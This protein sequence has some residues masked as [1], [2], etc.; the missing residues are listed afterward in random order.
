MSGRFLSRIFAPLALSALVLGASAAASSA[1]AQTS[2][3]VKLEVRI[4]GVEG[5][6]LANVEAV[7]G[8]V[9]AA[10]SG[11]VR[12]GHVYRLFEQ[13]PEEIERALEPFG[14]YRVRVESSLQSDTAPWSATFVIDRGPPILVDRLEVSIEGA[15]AQDSAFQ[16]AL[17]RIA[18]A[19]GDT[20]NHPAYERAKS[21]IELLAADRGYLDARW[22]S[23]FIRVDLDDYRSEIVLDM[24][25]GPRF[26][27]GPVTIDQDWV[28]LCTLTG[29]ERI[30]RNR[31]AAVVLDRIV[32]AIVAF[33]H[34]GLQPFLEDWR[35]HDLVRDRQV[36]LQLPNEV[37]RGRARGI[38][39]G[40]ALL[41]DTATGRRRFASGEVSLRI[42]P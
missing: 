7:T 24:T 23:A 13:A 4:T 38:D 33:E 28:D 34:S 40:G 16:A 3:G 18:L 11:V 2:E 15:A 5:A 30:S 17:G 32:E 12:P 1:F 8:I 20:L 14:Y 22:D 9:R 39:A 6:L 37:I 19:E 41:V 25:T 29:R 26:R 27:F 42:A 21:S 36:S 35:R 10:R 31:L